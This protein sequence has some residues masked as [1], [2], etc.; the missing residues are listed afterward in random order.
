MLCQVG[1]IWYIYSQNQTRQFGRYIDHVAKYIGGRY[2][3]FKSVEQPGAV[4]EQVPEALQIEAMRF[5]NVFV[6]PT[7]LL[8]KKILSLTG[9]YPL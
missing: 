6:T 1:E 3:T 4:Y 5:L 9:S 7:W 2:E 8:D